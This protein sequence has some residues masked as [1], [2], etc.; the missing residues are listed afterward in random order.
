LVSDTQGSL[1]GDPPRSPLGFTLSPAPQVLNPGKMLSTVS[2]VLKLG[3]MLSTAPR[4]L[5]AGLLM[6]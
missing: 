2:Q 3:K 4:V 6:L 5:K 1:G